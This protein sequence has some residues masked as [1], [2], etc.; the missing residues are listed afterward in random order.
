[1]D[2]FGENIDFMLFESLREDG[3]FLEE[4]GRLSKKL[5][6]EKLLTSSTLRENS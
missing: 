1:M 4:Q 2:L 5:K 3:I 6:F